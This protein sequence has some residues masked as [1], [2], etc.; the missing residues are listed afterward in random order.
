LSLLCSF[1]NTSLAPT[2]S[3]LPYN[4]LISKAAEEKRTLVRGSMMALLVALDHHIENEEM[5]EGKEDNAF[6]YFF[7]KLVEYNVQAE[8]SIERRISRSF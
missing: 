3:N 7:S 8:I 1:L 2:P 4:Y 5:G 6:R